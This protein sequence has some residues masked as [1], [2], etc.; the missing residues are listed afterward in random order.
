MPN[1][2][3][4]KHVNTFIHRIL[5][6][7]KKHDRA[8][9][10]SEIEEKTGINVLNNVQ[11]VRALKI[12]PKVAIT[13]E[14]IQF[15]PSYVV[16]CM[17][18]LVSILKKVNG[19]EGIEMNKLLESPIDISPFINKLVQQDKIIILKDIDDSEIVFFN[20]E[21]LPTL[22]KE[23]KDLWASVKVPNLHDITQELSEGGLKGSETCV[24]KKQKATKQTKQKKNKRRITITNTHVKGLDLD[25]L[26]ESD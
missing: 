19:K 21:P 5:D 24:L 9:S 4:S 13:H 2:D 6:F 8:L 11:L 16:R 26:N 18:D 1:A 12:N 3:N 17:E 7:L 23:I 14:S 10:Y 15:L 20:E 25:N 22:K